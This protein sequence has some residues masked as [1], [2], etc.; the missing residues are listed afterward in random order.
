MSPLEL[1]FFIKNIIFMIG[2][3]IL[4]I[5]IIIIGVEA[6]INYIKDTRIVRHKL[7]PHWNYRGDEIQCSVCKKVF[8]IGNGQNVPK[9][10]PNCKTKI[11]YIQND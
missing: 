4:A 2:V 10:C 1:H 11:K 6:L 7:K 5:C 8:D 3:I 9:V